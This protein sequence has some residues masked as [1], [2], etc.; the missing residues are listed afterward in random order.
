MPKGGTKDLLANIRETWNAEMKVAEGRA[1][2]NEQIEIEAE[3]DLDGGEAGE[4]IQTTLKAEKA[5]ASETPAQAQARVEG[6]MP[7]K[8]WEEAG[9]D[10]DM[11]KPAGAY[12]ADG[13]LRKD[14]RGLKRALTK[15]NKIID[16]MLKERDITYKAGQANVLESLKA[17]RDKAIEEDDMKKVVAIS[18]KIA[19]VQQGEGQTPLEGADVDDDTK[20]VADEGAQFTPD[21]VKEIQ[22]WAVGQP[23]YAM[24]T[25]LANYADIVAGNYLDTNEN[26]SITDA[27]NHAAGLVRRQFPG[28][29]KGTT[30]RAA[31]PVDA[32]PQNRAGNA[33]TD[34]VQVLSPS[35]LSSVD[36]FGEE[37]Y[38]IYRQYSRAGM[39]KKDDKDTKG[40]WT[41]REWAINVGAVK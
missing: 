34:T 15:R 31:G 27:L 23:W 30:R 24:D 32:G 38:R 39:F 22:A 4:S 20:V 13:E 35:E 3:G 21:E 14:M 7:R 40:K 28:R 18:D 10:P 9:K 29:F 17:D 16:S 1:D 26:A 25:Q 36:D 6:W 41:Y 19:E 33:A 12:L 8:E 2:P 11:W 37:L 5:Q